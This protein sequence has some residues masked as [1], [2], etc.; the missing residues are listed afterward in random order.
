MAFVRD[1]VLPV[2]GYGNL[3]ET[4]FSD[5]QDGSGVL[6]VTDGSDHQ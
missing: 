3:E 4:Q 1:Y 2:E 5:D 6:E